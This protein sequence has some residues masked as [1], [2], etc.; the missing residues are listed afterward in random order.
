MSH[1]A[2]VTCLGASGG[3]HVLYI[4]FFSTTLCFLLSFTPAD[5][6]DDKNEDDVEEEAEDEE[7]DGVIEEEYDD[8]IISKD[9][10]KEVGFSLATVELIHF[11]V[12]CVVFLCPV[13]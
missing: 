7:K 2:T 1:P 12:N 6:N 4:A 13:M 3:D 8:E 5:E 10:T 9:Q 11:C